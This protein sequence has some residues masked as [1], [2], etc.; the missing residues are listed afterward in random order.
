MVNL[1]SEVRRNRAAL[2]LSF[3]EGP[4]V[5][6]QKLRTTSKS[7]FQGLPCGKGFGKEKGSNMVSI[8]PRV[9]DWERRRPVTLHPHSQD[10]STMQPSLRRR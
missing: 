5:W 3:L 4:G 1:E 10:N 9:G 8:G 6:G 7:L 2:E